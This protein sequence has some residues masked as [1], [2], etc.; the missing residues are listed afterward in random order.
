MGLGDEALETAS[1]Q[2]KL[3]IVSLQQIGIE[4]TAMLD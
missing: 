2:G 3:L 4:T 1:L